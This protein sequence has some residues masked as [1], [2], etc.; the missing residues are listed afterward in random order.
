ME[1]NAYSF[2]FPSS[3]PGYSSTTIR[4]P[5]DPSEGRFIVDMMHMDNLQHK[6]SMRLERKTI[7]KLSMEAWRRMHFHPM[8]FPMLILLPVVAPR[9][10][11]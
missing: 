7:V 4:V 5:R 3:S 8:C 9:K 11:F 1:T 6:M 2:S 10:L